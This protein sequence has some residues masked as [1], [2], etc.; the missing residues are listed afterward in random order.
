M[1]ASLV[2][3]N[4][5]RMWSKTPVQVA[6]FERG[7][8]DRRLVDGDDLVELL[9]AV[10]A[11][12]ETGWH[13]RGVDPLHQRAQQDLV[14]QGR[15]SGTG[16][17]RDTDELPER[18]LDADVLQVVLL[19]THNRDDVAVPRT[20]STGYRDGAFPGQVLASDGFL[21]LEQLLIGAAV[22][23]G[24][25]VL[26]GARAD[27]DDVIGDLHRVLVVLD[28]EHRVAE[29]AHPHERLDEAL[30]VAL[31]QADR[32]LVEHVQHANQTRTNLRREPDALGFAAGEGRGVAR[33]RQI[34]KADIE[35]ETQASVDLLEDLLGD[36]R[37]AVVEF[38]LTERL[39]RIGDRHRA[40]VTDVVPV[41][42]DRKGERV[43][44]SAAADLTRH[45]PH[46]ALDLLASG[47]ALG[48]VVAPHQVRDHTLVP[49]LIRARGHSDSCSGPARVLSRPCRAEGESRC[50]FE[51][52]SHGRSWGSRRARRSIRPVARSSDCDHLPT[53][54]SPTRNGLLLVGITSRASTSNTV[55]RPSQCEQ[56]PYGELKEKFL[57]A[58]HRT[59]CRRSGAT[60]VG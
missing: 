5:L 38:E 59:T 26:A 17:A 54:E 9:H 25:A 45:L 14:D 40:E 27:V 11:L 57:G 36:D 48:L 33:H 21:V 18:E 32:G 58:A 41:D 35:E 37:I 12:V 22:H 15:L 55:P 34:I 2:W 30:V 7:P 24:S 39:C 20:T 4:S 49:R 29:I 13:L 51:S 23:D 44:A 16:H 52:F 56:A 8:P 42:R 47:V 3:A 10:D 28:D 50:F 43:E 60:G 46:V 31:M 53:A 6:G 19:G 1:L